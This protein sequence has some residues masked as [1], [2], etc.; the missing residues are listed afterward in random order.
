MVCLIT[1]TMVSRYGRESGEDGA[2]EPDERTLETFR[3]VRAAQR[4]AARYALAIQ[5]S[6]L[7]A[8]SRLTH[9]GRLLTRLTG[10]PA[11][12]PQEAGKAGHHL[13]DRLRSRGMSH[14]KLALG[15]GLVPKAA[16][17]SQ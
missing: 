9:S 13:D 7:L 6:T 4:P 14:G 16:T 2:V 17:W 3:R 1:T 5:A 10:T 12:A 11:A 15:P 8:E